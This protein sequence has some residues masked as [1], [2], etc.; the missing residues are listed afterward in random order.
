M[1]CTVKYLLAGVEDI[2][3]VLEILSVLFFF[4]PYYPDALGFAAD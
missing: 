1:R 4:Q 3:S 2:E